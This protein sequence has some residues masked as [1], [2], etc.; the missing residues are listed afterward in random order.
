MITRGS[1]VFFSLALAAYAAAVVYGVVTNGLA[2]GGVVATISGDGAIDA[3][4]GPLTLGY[5]GGVGDHVGY[6]V[7]MGFALASL[8]AGVVTVAFR[9]G[10]PEAVAELAHADAVPPVAAPADLSPWPLVGGVG[11]GVVT[12]GLATNAAIFIAGLTII[13]IAMLEW[14]VKAWSEQATGDPEV[15]RLIRKRLMHPVELPVAG[16]LIALIAAVSISQV[17][18]TS[19]KSM[20]VVVAAVLAGLI[21]VGA[22]MLS[23]M[24]ELKRSIIVGVVVA[25]AA[26]VLG[27]GIFGAVRG[28]RDFEEHGGSEHSAALVDSARLVPLGETS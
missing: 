9:D 1:K 19:S 27:L 6:S 8:F 24:P 4:V 25:V 21:L 20:A 16:L 26:L 18:L 3:L 28:A 17:F 23:L 5:K 11:V 22:V 14:T 15:N 7:L 13:G 10:D 2:T 12:L